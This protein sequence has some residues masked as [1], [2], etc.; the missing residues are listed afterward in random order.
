MLAHLSRFLQVGGIGFAID[1]GLLWF[2]IYQLEMPPIVSRLISFLI[3]ICVT[4]ILNATYTF[5]VDIKAAS[6]PRY[7]GVQ[8]LGAGINFASYSWLVLQGPLNDSPL[9]ALVV[10][11]ALAAIHNFLMMRRFVFRKR[12]Y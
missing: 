3:T 2:L 8:V 12:S 5:V 10:G 11:S 9:V 1:A 6:M 7:V 4:F